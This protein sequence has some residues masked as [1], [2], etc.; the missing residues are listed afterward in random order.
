M[1]HRRPLLD[2]LARHARR[3]PEDAATAARIRALVETHADCF[4][5]TCVPGHITA[6]A[7]I[8]SADRERCLLTHH[9]KL[10]RWL[11]L[12]GHA[13]GET[14][15]ARVALAEAREE[16][17]MA[18]FE[19]FPEPFDVDVHVIP[20][21]GAEPEHEHHDV[22][23]LLVAAPGQEIRVGDESHDVRWFGWDELEDVVVDD[24]G[25]LRLARRAR[26]A[27]GA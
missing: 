21:R 27:L 26:R 17:G 4:E 12:G 24:A 13:D 16:S 7:W 2:L 10:G 15:V 5:R 23:F 14:D 22:R 1:S 11:Q 9:R 25:I 8:V 3:F 6:S 18:E 19:L 20:A